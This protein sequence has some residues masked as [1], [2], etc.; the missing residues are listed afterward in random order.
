MRFERKY[1]IA[2][3]TPETIRQMI[4]LHPAG[5]RVLHPRRKINNIYFDALT[6]SALDQ[7][8]YGVNERKKFR[9]RWYGEDSSKIHNA[10]L[11]VKIKHNELGRKELF[12]FPDTD[13]TDMNAITATVNKLL[14]PQAD[15]QPVLLSSYQR[16]YYISADGKFRLTI[17]SAMK[18]HSLR[19]SPHFHGYPITDPNVVIE[20]KY[21]RAEDSEVTFITQHIPF[22]QEKHSKYVSGMFLTNG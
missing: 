2:G 10:K 20:V 11:E 6:L 18:Y 14:Y 15:L 7:N 13:L 12:A 16:E 19:M 1:R 17:D 3:K 4:W 8:V 5:F 22:R 21:K 9:L